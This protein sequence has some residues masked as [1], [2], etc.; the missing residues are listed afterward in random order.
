MQMC[1]GEESVTIDRSLSHREDLERFNCEERRG[2]WGART[3][4]QRLKKGNVS[5]QLTTKVGS[6]VA[7]SV[8]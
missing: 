5:S 7:S 6:D 1:M 2:K 3:S 8:F 4:Y